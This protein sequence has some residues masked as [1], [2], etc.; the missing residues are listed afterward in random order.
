MAWKIG[1]VPFQPLGFLLLMA[2][3][4]QRNAPAS[5]AASR[6]TAMFDEYTTNHLIQLRS[7]C[8]DI[9]EQLDECEQRA[10]TLLLLQHIDKE[11][12][13]REYKQSA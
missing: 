4:N 6:C 1:R 9:I 10:D 12:A 8:I 3:Q 13:M 11:L 7:V 5:L 2:T